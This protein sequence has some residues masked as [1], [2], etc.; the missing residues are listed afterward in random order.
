MP[1]PAIRM[2]VCPVA[3]NVA[4][5]PR[6][7]NA[8]A[9]A[10]AVYFLPSAQSVPSVSRRWPVRG[11]PDATGMP[12]GRLPHVDQAPPES[13]GGFA[14]HGEVAQ[15]RMHAADRGRG[16]LPSLRPARRATTG[17]MNPPALATPITIACAPAACACAGVRNGRPVRDRR[18]RAARTRRGS[19][20]APSRATRT[21][22]SRSPARWCRRGT[23][24]KAAAA[25]TSGIGRSAKKCATTGPRAASGAV[26]GSRLRSGSRPRSR[27]CAAG[28]A[29]PRCGA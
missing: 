2:P 10:S 1:P 23:T 4:S 7:W 18:A 25:Q 14:Q 9:S 5:T 28:S 19:V 16:P 26:R 6:A 8:R 12:R 3:R 22:S 15:P 20:R 27:T 11:R 13:L 29:S 24:G 21:R 17:G